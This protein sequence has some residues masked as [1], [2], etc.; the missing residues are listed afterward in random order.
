MNPKLSIY[1]LC[2]YVAAIRIPRKTMFSTGL[3][4]TERF[5]TAPFFIKSAAVPTAPMR[6]VYVAMA[7]ALLS[8]QWPRVKSGNFTGPLPCCKDAVLSGPGAD[9]VAAS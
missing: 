9:Q 3:R 2:V 4:T 5:A 8:F 7:E 6:H 1:N